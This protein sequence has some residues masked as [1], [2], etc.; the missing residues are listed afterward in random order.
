MNYDLIVC[1]RCQVKIITSR[2]ET[3]LTNPIIVCEVCLDPR[4]M[5][6]SYSMK[7]KAVLF[8]RE[9]ASKLA[10]LIMERD[11]KCHILRSR[12]LATFKL[13]RFHVMKLFL[14]FFLGKKFEFRHVL[15]TK[16]EQKM[17]ENRRKERKLDLLDRWHPVEAT[18]FF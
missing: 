1:L 10:E 11:S 16:R 3:R 7:F 12:R 17:E 2:G 4:W 18:L 15:P 6:L 8:Q 14:Y 9:R 5:C 13:C